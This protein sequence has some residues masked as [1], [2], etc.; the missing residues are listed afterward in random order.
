MINYYPLYALICMKAI[1]NIAV[2]S[3]EL[4]REKRQ[5]Y[6]AYEQKTTSGRYCKFNQ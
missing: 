3:E 4:L 5:I 6:T 2:S 1:N